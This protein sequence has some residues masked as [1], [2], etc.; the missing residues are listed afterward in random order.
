MIDL[1]SHILPGVDDGARTLDES[2]AIARAAVASGVQLM[3]ATPHVR[4]DYQTTPATMERLL[5]ETRAA[6]RSAGIELELRGGAEVAL[7]FLP[8]L[9]LEELHRFGLAGNPRYLLLEFPYEGWPLGLET[10]VESLRDKGITAVLAHPER[11]ESVQ[12]SPLQLVPAATE[13]AL[14]QL[15]ASS[16]TGAGGRGARRAAEALLDRE[17]AHLVAGDLHAPGTRS[18]LDAAAEA[19]GGG[20]LADWLTTGVPSAIAHDEPLPPRPPGRRHRRRR[21]EFRR[22]RGD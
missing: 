6:L 18:G 5:Q 7:G 3:A 12:V 9:G 13:G 19:L 10:T 1:H 4:A 17:L 14:V 21:L 16:L 8:Q 11:S 2:L 15:T 22:G 20:A